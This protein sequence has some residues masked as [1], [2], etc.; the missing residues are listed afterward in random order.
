MARLRVISCLICALLILSAARAAAAAPSFPPTAAAA[1]VTPVTASPSTPIPPAIGAAAGHSV[2]RFDLVGFGNR[3][4]IKSASLSCTGGAA[5]VT[6]AAH[7]LLRDFWGK[8]LPSSQQGVVWSETS[9]CM[10]DDICWLTVCS[11]N[12][13]FQSPTFTGVA[14]EQGGGDASILL[15]ITGRSRVTIRQGRFTSSTS[16]LFIAGTNASVLVEECSFV[17]LSHS[18]GA[19]MLINGSTVHVARSTFLHN[20][21]LLSGGGAIVALG[22]RLH[23]TAN[24]FQHNSAFRYG[25][26][27]TAIQSR[28]YVGP[29]AF[30]SSFLT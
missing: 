11:S 20:E 24:T 19:G 7:K 27:I 25:G 14:F 17:G 30:F 26:A 6:V 29:G 2:C 4:G 10:P 13:V 22:A 12:A 8:S 5:P 21:A 15:C 1:G 23:L 18:T 28:L 9:S 3:P 16:A